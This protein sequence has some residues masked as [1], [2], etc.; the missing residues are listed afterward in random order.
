MHNPKRDV[1]ALSSCYLLKT[2]ITF[3]APSPKK[4]RSCFQS[5]L[6]KIPYE[7]HVLLK[8]EA[9]KMTTH[10]PIVQLERPALSKTSDL[11]L[12]PDFP[13]FYG[14]HPNQLSPMELLMELEDPTGFPHGEG[15]TR[16]QLLLDC[17][18][19][20]CLKM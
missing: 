16:S 20:L 1:K 17:N 6:T 7:K 11:R 8:E 13:A 3:D 14:H 15:Q 9:S 12:P 2:F 19:G 10:V 4:P 18:R 5:P